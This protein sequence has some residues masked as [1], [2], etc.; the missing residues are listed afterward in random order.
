L[1]A[2]PAK[3]ARVL[4]EPDWA[5]LVRHTDVENAHDM[6]ETL[7]T[8]T[9]DC[10]FEDMALG[11]TYQGRAGA[12]EYYRMWWEGVDATVSV[13]RVHP[14]ADQP[15]AVAETLWR[16]RHVGTFLDIAS[17]GRSIEVPVIIVAEM[18]DGLLA[19][20]RLYWDRA[21]VLDQL[22]GPQPSA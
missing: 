15:I 9:T 10:V 8:L 4:T 7:A 6:T 13:E 22:V 1:S 19:R 14:V 12:A 5:L 3:E 21:T 18:R 11:S 20:E 2:E 17:T 16:G